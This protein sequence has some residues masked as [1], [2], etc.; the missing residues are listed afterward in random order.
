MGEKIKIK[1]IEGDS[2]AL[3]T[4]FESSDCSLGEYLNANKRP[5]IKLS[6]LIM[7][8][9]AFVIISCLLWSLPVHHIICRK[10]FTIINFAL[11]GATTIFLHLYWRNY[12]VTCIGAII[13]ICLFGIS[14][15]AITP[16]EAAQTVNDRLEQFDK[17]SRP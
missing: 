14:I 1:E 9:L 6:I 5:R 3:A 4:F 7:T 2:D 10:I 16:Q 12:F 17:N 8:T 15:D 13:G 11:F